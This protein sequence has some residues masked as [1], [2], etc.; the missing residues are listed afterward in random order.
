MLFLSI[1]A[2][3]DELD[4]EGLVLLSLVVLCSQFCPYIFRLGYS[5]R[6]QSASR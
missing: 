1:K 6:S 3:Y 2:G 5:R 4:Y